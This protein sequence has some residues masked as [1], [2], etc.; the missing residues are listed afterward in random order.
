MNYRSAR[1]ILGTGA[2]ATYTDI[3]QAFRQKIKEFHPDL[4]PTARP[5][6]QREEFE[7]VMEAYRFPMNFRTQFQA[8]R[9]RSRSNS[10]RR[11]CFALVKVSNAH[12]NPES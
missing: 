5:Q 3:K 11:R 8:D 7:N 12:S 2:C 4:N 10:P 1:L 6:R 9:Y